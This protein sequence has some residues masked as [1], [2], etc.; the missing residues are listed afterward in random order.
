M[1]ARRCISYLTI[2][3]RSDIDPAL[4]AKVGNWVFGCDI[5]QEV[6]PH[7]REAPMTTEP[8]FAPTAPDAAFPLLDDI[9]N[10]N[11]EA[12]RAAVTNKATDR[13][14]LDMWK[15]NVHIARS[16]HTT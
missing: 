10:W 13:A 8:R 5:C 11:E 7:N 6:C 9:N 4:A 14:R 2:E 15:R 1:D 16:N 3:H 12:Y